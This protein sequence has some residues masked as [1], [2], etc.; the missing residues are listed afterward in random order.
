MNHLRLVAT[1]LTRHRTRTAI[2]AMGI[3]LGVAAMFTVVAVV[4]GAIGMFEGILA[5]D[6]EM[7][8]FE[9]DVSDLFFSS[10]KDEDWER[11]RALDTVAA[12]HPLL[13]GL[14]SAEDHPVITC[15]GLVKGD[16]RLNNATWLAGEH[17]AFGTVDGEIVLGQRAAGFLEAGLNDE[18]EIGNETFKVSGIIHTRNGFEDGGVFLH[19]NRRVSFFTATVCPPFS[20]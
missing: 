20:P 18:I 2:G 3:A 4:R 11:I 17:D 15:F 8:V 6:S 13:F 5:A 1:N 12:A 14:V 7:L 19:S 9:R 10:V 16:P